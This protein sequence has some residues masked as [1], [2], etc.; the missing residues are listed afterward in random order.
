MA[1][2]AHRHPQQEAVELRLRQPIDAFLLD[3]VLRRQ[4]QE[5]LRQRQRRPLDRDLE[6][7]HR[8]QQ[9]GLRLGR[10]AV[11]LVGEQHLAEDRS[12][13]QDELVGLAV[14]DVGAGDVARQQVRRELDALVLAAEDAGERLGERRLGDAG[15]AFDQDVPGGEQG[16]EQLLG[17]A[18]MP[19][20]TRPTSASDPIPQFADLDGRLAD[21][22]AVGLRG[23]VRRDDGRGGVR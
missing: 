22:L 5:R 11:D 3:R 2:I 23:N 19:T 10:G 9:G 16:D 12:L 15:D 7:L 17:D 6:F 20:T 21:G 18:S 8:F 1:G 14:E 4:H 13:A